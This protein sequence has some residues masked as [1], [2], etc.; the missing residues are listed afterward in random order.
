V[1]KTYNRRER[2]AERELAKPFQLRMYKDQMQHLEELGER[3]GGSI[4][5][6]LRRIID[7][8]IEHTSN[9][10]AISESLIDI[11]RQIDEL[12]EKQNLSTGG[13]EGISIELLLLLRA[14]MRNNGGEQNIKMVQADIKQ[15]GHTP[16][17]IEKRA[18]NK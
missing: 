11:R 2:G 13:D 3:L 16:F 14:L 1:S 12:S 6:H 8:S 5:D 4:S 15:L 18:R 10:D 9:L 17:E 7:E